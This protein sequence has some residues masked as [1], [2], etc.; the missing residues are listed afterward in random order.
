MGATNVHRVLGTLPFGITLSLD[1]I[2]GFAAVAIT[3]LTAAELPAKPMLCLATG[4]AAVAGHTLSFWVSFKGGKG[5][6]TGLGVFLALAPKASIAVMGVFLFTL[7]T[8]GFVSLGSILSATALP[9]MIW[10]FNEGGNELNRILAGFAAIIALFV[11]IK[12]RSNIKRLLKGEENSFRS[13]KH[14]NA[15]ESENNR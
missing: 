14:M 2:K 8:S 1:I 10:I 7:L 6:A 3:A 11:I 12:H 9:I 4:A 15:D 13:K 5:V